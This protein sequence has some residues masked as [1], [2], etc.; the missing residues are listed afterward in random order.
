LELSECRLKQQTA[1]EKSKR[2]DVPFVHSDVRI[3]SGLDE[4]HNIMKSTIR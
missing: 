1:D 3:G 4:V 2:D